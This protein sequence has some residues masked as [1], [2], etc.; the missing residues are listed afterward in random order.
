MS[1]V[2]ENLIPGEKIEYNAKITRLIYLS[3]AL[4]IMLSIYGFSIAKNMGEEGNAIGGFSAILMLFAFFSLLKAF[5][6]RNTTELVVTSKRVVYKTGLI[7]RKT[8]ELNHVKVESMHVDQGIIGRLLDYGT[9]V[10]NGT[11]G[12]KTPIPSVDSPLEFRR[13]AM[14]VVDSSQSSR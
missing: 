1:Y 2:E 9:L 7:R 3:G 8:I 13:Q 6:V 10:I 14:I 4:M 5:I 11:G 12:G